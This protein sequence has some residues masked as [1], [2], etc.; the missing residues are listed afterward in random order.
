MCQ[1]IQLQISSTR[2]HMLKGALSWS[3]LLL[4]AASTVSAQLISIRTVPISQEAQFNI[5]P[6]ATAPMGGI[7]IAVS[8]PL[9]D[10]FINPA[11]GAKLGA[12]RFFGSPGAYSVS[13][14]AGGGRTL[15]IGALSR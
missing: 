7:S 10:P 14:S 2:C 11:Y 13:S 1:G 6:S 15:P 9:L 3:A 12:T 4:A 8:D 5:F